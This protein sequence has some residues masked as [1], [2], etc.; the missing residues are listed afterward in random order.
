MGLRGKVAH[1]HNLYM[2]LG[3]SCNVRHYPTINHY[4]GYECQFPT[5]GGFRAQHVL[6]PDLAR[7]YDGL[8]LLDYSLG[9]LDYR[10]FPVSAAKD[11]I[12]PA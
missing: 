10:Q 9:L 6:P 4:S 2:H 3:M 12:Q 1:I 11:Q 7:Q 5:F 8:R